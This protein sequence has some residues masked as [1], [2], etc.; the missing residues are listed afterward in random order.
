MK[1]FTPEYIHHLQKIIEDHA[2]DAARD[3]LKD[4]HPAEIAELYHELDIDEAEYLY[5][6][7]DEENQADVLMELDEDERQ[8]LLSK[9]DAEDIAKQIEHLDTDDAVDVIQELDEDE[10]EKIL[11][12]IDDVEQA[13]DIIDLLKYDEDTAGGLMGTEMIVVNENWSMPECI[14]QMRMQAED[15][16]EVYYVYV[17]DND[18]RLKGT[19]PLKKLITHPSVSKIKHV[20]EDDPVAVK[21]DTPIDEVALDFEKYD[22][23]AMPVVDSIGRL[24]GRI[25]VDDVM[26]QVRDSNER[27]YQLASG[28]THDVE[29]DDK[30]FAQTKAR[31]PW[32]LIGM[33]GGLCNSFILGKFEGGFVVDP[34]L[35]LF[36]PL[37]GGTGGNVGTQSSAIVVQGLAN[38]SL[39]IKKSTQQLLKELG[40]GLLNGGIIALLVFIYNYFTIGHGHEVTTFAVSISLFCV[41]MFASVFGTFVPLTL[42]KLKIDPALATG[43]F[44]SITN[45]IIGM[46]IYMSISSWLIIALH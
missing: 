5:L 38:G 35:A 27:D 15:M 43:P 19:L 23:V 6:L 46:L 39:D 12:H 42:E 45:D 11:S 33:I 20:M 10:R 21:A 4:L 26:D 14:R 24:L 13:G 17:V 16:D 34:A 37:I 3:E 44:I 36:I 2:D 30:L 32:L 31:L 8:Q 25:T 9:M 18:D 29:S 1:D 7:L 22:L 28:L 40:V 41:V